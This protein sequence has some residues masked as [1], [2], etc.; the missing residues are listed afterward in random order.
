MPISKFKNAIKVSVGNSY[1]TI[2]T[3]PANKDSYVIELDVS[4]TG[5][6]GVQITARLR[7]VSAAATAHIVKG[8]PIPLGSALQVI[9]GQKIVLEQ[10][11]YIELKCDTPGETVDA[12]ISVVEDVNN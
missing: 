7:D 10:G 3:A 9:D 5:T 8:A 1:Q 11:D 4:T 12:I 2:Y 6:T